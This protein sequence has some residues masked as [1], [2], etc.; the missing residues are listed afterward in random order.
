MQNRTVDRADLQF[1]E[2]RVGKFLGER[3][4]IPGKPRLTH[5]DRR[6]ERSLALPAIDETGLG[7]EGERLLTGFPEQQVGQ[8][9]HAVAAGTR[10]RTVIVIDAYVS[11]GAWRTRRMQHHE[12]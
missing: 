6:D 12:L 3:N 1:D 10:F 11:V 7:L 5:V 4:L 9:A 8:A 2:T